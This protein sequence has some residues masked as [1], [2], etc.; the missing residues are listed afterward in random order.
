MNLNA[1]RFA[2]NGGSVDNCHF[3]D[4]DF[5]CCSSEFFSCGYVLM[6]DAIRTF[7]PVISRYDMNSTT[8][9]IRVIAVRHIRPQQSK[10]ISKI[11]VKMTLMNK[12]KSTD[13]VTCQSISILL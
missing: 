12:Q 8:I 3:N 5:C 7:D 1:G 2:V 10:S 11:T 4:I 9:Q 6:P 13:Y